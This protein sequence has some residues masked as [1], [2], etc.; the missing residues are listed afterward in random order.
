[1]V[2]TMS[3]APTRPVSW[4]RAPARSATAVRDPLVLTGKPWKSPA[5]R[6]AAPMPIISWLPSTSCP[7]RAANE[8]DVEMVSAS[9]DQGDAERARGERGEVGPA[10][11]W[12]S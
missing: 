7:V 1:M 4:L 5:A 3:A 8:D 6:F 9:D 10:R 11:P 2:R 12:G